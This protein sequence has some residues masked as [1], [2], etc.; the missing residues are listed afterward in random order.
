LKLH[1]FNSLATIFTGRAVMDNSVLLKILSVHCIQIPRISQVSAILRYNYA[2]TRFGFLLVKLFSKS[3]L[4]LKKYGFYST[5]LSFM[6]KEKE[7]K[8]GTV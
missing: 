6:A 3:T 8:I 2:I 5:L 7:K 4:G 1:K